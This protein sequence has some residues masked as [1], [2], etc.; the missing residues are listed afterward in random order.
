[1]SRTG[2]V[3]SALQVFLNITASIHTDPISSNTVKSV[4]IPV[5]AESTVV[6]LSL[7]TVK[8]LKEDGSKQDIVVSV[9]PDPNYNVAPN[10]VQTAV[11]RLSLPLSK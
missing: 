2:D 3:S 5:G 4:T 8:D 7:D 10:I 11:Q 1:V 9:V 6:S